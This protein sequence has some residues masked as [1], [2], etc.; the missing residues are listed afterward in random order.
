MRIYAYDFRDK[1]QEQ[2]H[3]W[4]DIGTIDAYY[5][6]SMDLVEARAPFD[7]YANDISP[8]Q[9]TRH[10]HPGGVDHISRYAPRLHGT[11]RV[12]RTVLSPGVQVEQNATVEDSVLM[13]GVRI[14]KGVQL[15]R[16]IVEEG[17]EIPAGF[18]AG[19]DVEHDRSHYTVTESGVVVISQQR[20]QTKIM[21]VKL[22]RPAMEEE[23]HETHAHHRH[24]LRRA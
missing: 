19:F 6:A 17:V 14:G 24:S 12:S 10:P 1:K 22:E 11:A 7:P 16:A 21:P 4:R 8:S 13:P 20:E 5:A 23:V 15:R 18:H 2:P 9:P 3:Y